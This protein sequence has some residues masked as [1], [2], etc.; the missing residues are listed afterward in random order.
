[1]TFHW[2]KLN[3]LVS[4]QPPIMAMP[5]VRLTTWPLA[6]L[7]TNVRSRV[8]LMWRAILAIA[9]SQEM[10]SQRS[11]PGRRTLGAVSRFLWRDVVLERWRP[12]DRASR[13]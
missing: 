4:V 10:S 11:D 5:G 3:S 12:W 13:G 9:S 6:F 8:S 7:A 1:M 2:R